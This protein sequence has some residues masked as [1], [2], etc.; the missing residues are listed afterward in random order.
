MRS[1]G[2]KVTEVMGVIWI[3]LPESAPVRFVS[4]DLCSFRNP[5]KIDNLH[6]RLVLSEE[7]FP[8]MARLTDEFGTQVSTTP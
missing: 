5:R 7:R 6:T 8:W 1:V 3:T 2:A 4:H